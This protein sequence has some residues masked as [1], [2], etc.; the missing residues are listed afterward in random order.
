[1][2]MK[3]HQHKFDMD[4]FNPKNTKCKYCNQVQIYIPAKR[5][6]VD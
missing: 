6:E 4:G 1:M 3:H 2:G 5:V